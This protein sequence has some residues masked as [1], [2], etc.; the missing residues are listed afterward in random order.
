MNPL[1]KYRNEVV[2]LCQKHYVQTLYVF[3]SILTERF[4]AESDIDLLVEFADVP[5]DD[6]ADNYFDFRFALEDI[7][8]RKVDLLERPAMKNPYLISAIL[9]TQKLLYAA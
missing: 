9:K 8:Q 2:A 6:Y 4:N 7:F 5:Q 3:G 1:V